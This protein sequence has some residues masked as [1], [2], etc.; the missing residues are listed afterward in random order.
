M[1]EPNAT[2]SPSPSA[3]PATP[4]LEPI[5]L[6]PPKPLP[7]APATGTLTKEELR[8]TVRE[9]IAA[10]RAAEP[11]EPAPDIAPAPL[12]DIPKAED[13]DALFQAGKQGEALTKMVGAVVGISERGRAQIGRERAFELLEKR[14]AKSGFYAKHEAGFLRYV[15]KL[16]LN[17]AQLQ[18]RE[19]AQRAFQF[20]IS[21][22]PQVLKE[23]AALDVEQ[24]STPAASAGG[25][26]ASAAPASGQPAVAGTPVPRV[27][28]PGAAAEPGAP[29]VDAAASLSAAELKQIAKI[30]GM[31]AE[32]YLAE[33]QRMASGKLRI[34]ADGMEV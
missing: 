24:P 22:S 10:A 14:Y 16:G 29:A 7:A 25:P 8:A 11:D 4:T 31:K 6:T 21:Q 5:K 34:S 26:A 2:P 32:D 30:P 13:I 33:K 27:E 23:F 3:D 18:T 9:A 17:D 12:P 20:Y 19:A 15:N 1:P 28:T